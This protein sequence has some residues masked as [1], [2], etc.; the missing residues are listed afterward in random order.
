MFTKEEQWLLDE[1]YHGL[2]TEGFL[3]DVKRLEV[4]EPLAYVIGYIPFLNTKISLDSKPLI[5]RTETEFWVSKVIEEIKTNQKNSGSII[6]VLDLCAG[7]GCIGIAVAK[8]LP[9]S[10][11]DFIELDKNHLS[12]IKNNC[13]QNGIEESRFRIFQGDLFSVEE[14]KTLFKYDFIISNPPY[15]DKDLDRTETSVKNFEPA[16][17]LYGGKA[18]LDLIEQIIKDAPQHLTVN[19]QLWIEHE[20]EQTE[21]IAELGKSIFSTTTHKDQYQ[22]QRFS[23]LVL[24]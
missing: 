16:I 24:Q 10:K 7:S 20:P 1:K 2:K 11:I 13:L 6:K 4:G 19:G 21:V 14:N 15:L 22:I 12:T 8:A 9:E 5:P 23:K 18:G 17:A 3:T